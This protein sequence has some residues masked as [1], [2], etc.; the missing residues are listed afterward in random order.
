MEQNIYQLFIN[1][2]S[3]SCHW[4]H[5]VLQLMTGDK[6]L[7]FATSVLH[8]PRRVQVFTP[9]SPM[10]DALAVGMSEFRLNI[11]SWCVT[12]VGFY[13]STWT[14][15]VACSERTEGEISFMCVGFR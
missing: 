8:P 13:I 10:P 15:W 7:F 6:Y 1:R 11:I 3:N 9:Q 14:A 4:S 12:N 5:K 2:F